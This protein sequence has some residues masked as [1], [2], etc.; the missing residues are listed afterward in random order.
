ML[1]DYLKMQLHGVSCSQKFC[2]KCGFP[3]LVNSR[4]SQFMFP[5][6][7]I[8]YQNLNIKKLKFESEKSSKNKHK[9]NRSFKRR[10]ELK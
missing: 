1:G 10:Q 7:L 2:S 3:N 4:T 5:K 9:S 6:H 8:E